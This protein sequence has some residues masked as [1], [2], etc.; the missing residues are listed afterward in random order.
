MLRRLLDDMTADSAV[1]T[2]KTVPNKEIKN[3]NLW[4]IIQI[5]AVVPTLA[6]NSGCGTDICTEEQLICPVQFRQG[7]AKANNDATGYFRNDATTE[8]A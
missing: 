3:K 1:P 7:F 8:C 4:V 6:C 5:D 2:D